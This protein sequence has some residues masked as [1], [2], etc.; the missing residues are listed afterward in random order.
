MF[1]KFIP[2]VM[3]TFMAACTNGQGSSE[4]K[5]CVPGKGKATCECTAC[6]CSKKA[7][8][9]CSKGNKGAGCQCGACKMCL[10]KAAEANASASEKPCKVCLESEKASMKNKN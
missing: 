9:T 8:C 3:L 5:M 10:G 2:L 1:K 7:E 4:P 6:E